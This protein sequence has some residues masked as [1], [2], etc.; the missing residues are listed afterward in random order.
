MS[1]HIHFTHK[2]IILMKYKTQSEHINKKLYGSAQNW[3]QEWFSYIL[4]TLED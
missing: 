4:R 3:I 1:P 2:C